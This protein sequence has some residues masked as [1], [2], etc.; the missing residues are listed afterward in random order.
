MVEQPPDCN[1]PSW[2][3]SW[4]AQSCDKGG[5]LNSNFIDLSTAFECFLHAFDIA[6]ACC[7]NQSELRT[8]ITVHWN[9]ATRYQQLVDGL[10]IVFLGEFSRS[11]S[12]KVPN[13]RGAMI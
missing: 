4:P 6:S 1:G 3:D 7:I 8:R 9:A 10:L 2:I 13:D 5:L 12:F 11:V